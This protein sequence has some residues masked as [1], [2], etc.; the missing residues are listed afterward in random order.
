MV[1]LINRNEIGKNFYPCIFTTM[2]LDYQAAENKKHPSHS[3]AFVRS[4]ARKL[5]HDTGTQSHGEKIL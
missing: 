2:V 4:Y 5:F 1:Y 3:Q